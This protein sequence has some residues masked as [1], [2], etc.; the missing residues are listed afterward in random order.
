L[1]EDSGAADE[2][3]GDLDSLPATFKDSSDLEAADATLKELAEWKLHREAAMAEERAKLEAQLASSERPAAPSVR[4]RPDPVLARTEG[5]ERA[6]QA[7]SS[8][9]AG[10]APDTRASDERLRALGGG[11]SPGAVQ[12]DLV[13]LRAREMA[14]ARLAEL[15][16]D[17]ATVASLGL[18][19]GD[20]DEEDEA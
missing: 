7:L 9:R 14:A 17:A 2:P 11:G 3:S 20:E 10:P 4:E 1:G 12:D 5:I 13:A 18:G 8:A 15:G 16:L 19:N 6:T